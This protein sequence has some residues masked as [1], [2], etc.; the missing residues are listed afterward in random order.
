MSS[1]F[2]SRIIFA[3]LVVSSAFWK[4][5]SARRSRRYHSYERNEVDVFKGIDNAEYDQIYIHYHGCVW[6]EFGDGY[7]C[8]DE[9]NNDMQEDDATWYLGHTQCYRANVAYSLYGIRTDDK[10]KKHPSNICKKRRYFINS[11]FTQNGM[12]D[13]GR[14]VGLVNGGDASSYCTVEDNDSGENNNDNGG[15]N[16]NDQQRQHGENI[17]SNAHS[18]TTYCTENGMFVTALFGGSYCSDKRNLQSVDS[19]DALNSELDSVGCL[20][21]YTKDQEDEADNEGDE[22]A[23][24]QDEEQV[25]NDQNDEGRRLTR[26]LE[27]Q[28]GENNANGSL[29]NLLAYSNMCSLVEYPR[30]CPDPFG[31]KK[32]FDLNASRS[33]GFWKQFMW[34]DWLTLACFLFSIV[35]VVMAFGLYRDRR[36]RVGAFTTRRG[37]LRSSTSSNTANRRSR[38]TSRERNGTINSRSKDTS[39]CS[40]SDFDGQNPRSKGLFR[41]WFAR[42]NHDSS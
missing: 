35:F 36:R 7:G 37:S 34:L 32:R 4:N 21:V 23:H 10:R 40:P 3:I 38:S 11:F 33:G 5:A 12:E 41:G 13:F 16:N 27:N 30:G 24:D 1:V 25:A 26:D 15:Y 6:S 9:G 29:W 18:Y 14:T 39:I 31:V 42:K 2:S 19:L 8:G 22:A 28:Q 17:N 20:L